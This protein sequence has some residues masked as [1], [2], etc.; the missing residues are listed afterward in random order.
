MKR[1]LRNGLSP[2]E[3]I[4]LSPNEILSVLKKLVSNA[5]LAEIFDVSTNVA[6]SLIE[7]DGISLSGAISLLFQANMS[8]R[9]TSLIQ[10]AVSDPGVINQLYFGG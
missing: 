5:Q 8:D 6:R 9:V 4:N 7:G 3:L 10:D 2:E 1:L